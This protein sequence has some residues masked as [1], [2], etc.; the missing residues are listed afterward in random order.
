MPKK[1]KEKDI[2]RK[3]NEI[4]EKERNNKTLTRNWK[5]LKDPKEREAM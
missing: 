2:I 3:R 1:K 5:N 4:E